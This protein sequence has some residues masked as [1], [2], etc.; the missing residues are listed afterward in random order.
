MDRKKKKLIKVASI[1]AL[2]IISIEIFIINFYIKS[3]KTENVFFNGINAY[4][5]TNDGYVVVG[6]NNNNDKH[7]EKAE[8]SVYDNSKNKKLV[9]V[10]NKGYNSTF[11]GVL[12]TDDGYVAVGS[13]ESTKQ[14]SENKVRTALIVKYD[15]SGNVIFEN[16]FQV[17][18]NS[19]FTNVVSTYDGFIVVGQSIYEND[20]IGLSN[21]GGAVI[22]KYD[23]DGKEIWRKNYGGSKS[24]LY[25][26]LTIYNNYIYAVGKDGNNMGIITKFSLEGDLVYNENY[27]NVDSIGFTSIVN[28][29]D[30]LYVCGGKSEGNSKQAIILKYNKDCKLIDE[31]TYQSN[32]NDRYNSLTIDENGN[33]IAVGTISNK[34]E[35]KD[36]SYDGIIGKYNSDLKE[37][38]V[39]KYTNDRSTYFNDVKYYDGK[40]LVIGNSQREDLSVVAKFFFFSTSLKSLG[41]N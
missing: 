29:N 11:Y 18:G 26:D 28:N 15:L 21:N 25:N 36:Y 33:V 19:K 2:I 7:Y 20:T 27:S 30:S 31:V 9:K 40:Y 35:S 10:Y 17:L 32:S 1:L 34:T 5:I 38:A 16:D 13:Y 41:V 3:N 23:K 6:S 12:C 39:V 24:A 8:I 4:E 14:E 22:I 37:L